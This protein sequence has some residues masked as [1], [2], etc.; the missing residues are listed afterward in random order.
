MKLFVAF[1]LTCTFI[2][3]DVFDFNT[4]SSEFKQSISNEENSKIVYEGSFYATTDSKAL[5]I[6]KSPIEKKIYFNQGQVVI[7]EPELEQVIITTLQNVPNLTEI[8]KSAKKMSDNIYNANYDDINYIIYVENN[9][10]KSISYKDK[11]ENNVKISLFN[12][13]IN[14][15]LDD[16]LFEV[17]IPS[18]Y[19]VLTQ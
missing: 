17:T 13:E 18:G 3:A 7:V 12:Q 5:W 10:I 8:L 4:I 9:L 11:L 16:K 2:F 6:Y 1:T 19:D 15:F 14:S